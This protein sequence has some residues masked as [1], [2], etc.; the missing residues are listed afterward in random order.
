MGGQWS[1]SSQPEEPG[2]T[3]SAQLSGVA[4][5]VVVEPSGEDNAFGN[6]PEVDPEGSWH[7]TEFGADRTQEVSQLILRFLPGCLIGVERG[8][9]R[10]AELFCAAAEH[11]RV[12]VSNSLCDRRAS[13]QLRVE[14][15]SRSE[16]SVVEAVEPRHGGSQ[17]DEKDRQQT[18]D[19][20]QDRLA[21]HGGRG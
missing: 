4:Y 13:Y 5:G 7:V 18:E 21:A 2:E 12:L 6:R 10:P 14:G 19:D 20:H 17:P 15:R 3:L 11:V 9:G 16:H 8:V 1:S